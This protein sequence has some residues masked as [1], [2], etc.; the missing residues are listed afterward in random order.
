MVIQVC[1]GSSCYIKGAP[2]IIQ[3]MQQAMADNGLDGKVELAGCFCTGQCNR[4]GVSVVVDGTVYPG[5][6]PKNF[7]TFFAQRVLNKEGE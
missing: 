1:V 4:E 2:E 7:D 3:R 5:I 6:T